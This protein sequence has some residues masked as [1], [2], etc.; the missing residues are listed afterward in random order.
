MRD[1]IARPH[2]TSCGFVFEIDDETTVALF[3]AL[4]REH[5]AAQH[6]ELVNPASGYVFNMKTGEISYEVRSDA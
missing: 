1:A 5:F 3:E 2:C 6:P 4:I